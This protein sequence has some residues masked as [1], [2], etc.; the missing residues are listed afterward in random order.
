MPLSAR[1]SGLW[2]IQVQIHGEG[3]LER[4]ASL[5][6]P[7]VVKT[8]PSKT[9]AIVNLK[10]SVDRSLVPNRDFVLYIRDE[11]L[12]KPTA[13]SAMTLGGQQAISVKILPDDRTEHEKSRVM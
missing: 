13:V 4:V 8:A 6:H 3:K 2:D 7:I 5:N 9:T 1:A 10:P 11:G 12:S